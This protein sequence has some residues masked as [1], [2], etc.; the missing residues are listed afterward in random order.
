MRQGWKER[1]GEER[2]GGVGVRAGLS[3]MVRMAL[4]V[5]HLQDMQHLGRSLAHEEGQHVQHESRPHPHSALQRDMRV[6]V[7]Q[8][9][10]N[11]PQRSADVE[12]HRDEADGA[13][14]ERGDEHDLVVGGDARVTERAVGHVLARAELRGCPGRTHGHCRG[15][16]AESVEA[17][18][19]PAVF[20]DR[21]IWLP[22]RE[23][24]V[25]EADTH[26]VRV[27]EGPQPRRHRAVPHTK[28]LQ[29]AQELW[30]LGIRQIR[31]HDRGLADEVGDGHER[32]QPRGEPRPSR[33]GSSHQGKVY[34]VYVGDRAEPRRKRVQEDVVGFRHAH[35]VGDLHVALQR[36]VE[37]DRLVSHRA[38]TGGA[39]TKARRTAQPWERC[40]GAGRARKRG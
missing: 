1:R 4:A 9:G 27:H 34:D 36:Q 5:A 20:A 14:S 2:R 30:R 38:Q 40:R 15:S 17:A 11:H 10:R 25:G 29:A 31:R 33:A 18:L 37:R 6:H 13:V 23:H 39:D 12:V 32:D 28:C 16:P 24:A 35:R 21:G 8:P 3:G 19:S 26:G 7:E 22:A